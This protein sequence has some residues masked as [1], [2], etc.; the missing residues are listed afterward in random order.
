MIMIKGYS[1]L[2]LESRGC[3]PGSLEFRAKFKF[4]SDISSLFPYINAVAKKP[5]Y[6]DKPHY[7][8]FVFNEFFCALYPDNGVLALVENKDQAITAIKKLIEFL[9]DIYSR[10]DSIEPNYK[11]FKH[12]PAL[13]IYK[14]LTKSNCKICGYPTCMSFA[15]ELGKGEVSLDKCPD[16]CNCKDENVIKLR[17]MLFE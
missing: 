8:K 7:I 11:K 14:L 6:F 12:I 4:N 9:N 16:L 5:L 13:N 15:A 10:K 2:N 17:A 3:H 1:D